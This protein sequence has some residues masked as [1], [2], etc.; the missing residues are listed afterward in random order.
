MEEVVRTH[1]AFT[2]YYD[3]L[4]RRRPAPDFNGAPAGNYD[5]YYL[6]TQPEFASKD[7]MN[8]KF[9]TKYQVQVAFVAGG[10][11]DNQSVF[12]TVINTIHGTSLAV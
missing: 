7:E 2:G 6:E 12:Q 4:D 5:I 9:S 3:Q 8:G 10:S 1:G 11:E